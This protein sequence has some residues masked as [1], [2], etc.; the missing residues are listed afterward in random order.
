MIKRL[1]GLPILLLAIL[2]LTQCGSND[3][4]F[5]LTWVWARP[6]DIGGNSAVY[7]TIKN[8][9]SSDSLISASTTIAETVQIHRTTANADGTV[10]M[11]EQERIDFKSGERVHFQPGGLHV[12][13]MNLKTP[14]SAGD[15]FPLNLEFKDAEDL[16]IEV[17]VQAP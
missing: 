4:Q 15:T 12:M 16:T 7:F 5:E 11:V 8:S 13:L 3:P 1:I 14:L 2:G 17:T 9:G 10:S 6:A